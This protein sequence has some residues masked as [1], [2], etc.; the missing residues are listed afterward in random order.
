MASRQPVR[1]VDQEDV[2]RQADAFLKLHHPTLV[3]PIP[4]E[5]IADVGM[6]INI[7]PHPNLDNRFGIVGWTER[8]LG[9]IHVDEYVYRHASEVRFRFT[10][11]HEIGHIVLHPN[12][13]K[14]AEFASPQEWKDYVNS[15][16]EQ[17]YRS[18][19]YQANLFAGM[20]LVPKP[21]LAQHLDECRAQLAKGLPHL[22]LESEEAMA[23][24]VPSVARRFLVSEEV[25][26]RRLRIEGL[27]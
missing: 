23:Y 18:L 5:E 14:D 1:F 20:V 7:Y 13:L 19:E 8:D 2:R 22:P 12:L 26:E 16:S 27:P 17:E 4:I 6:G 21:L 25:I 24:L 15:F 10:V 9:T 11:A 3:L